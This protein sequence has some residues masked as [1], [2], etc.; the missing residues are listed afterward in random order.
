MR[1]LKGQQPAWTLGPSPSALFG[2]NCPLRP[3]PAGCVA[4]SKRPDLSEMSVPIGLNIYSICGSAQIGKLRKDGGRW[5]LPSCVA[6][7]PSVLP[8]LP[9]G[10]TLNTNSYPRVCSK[11]FTGKGQPCMPPD[12]PLLSVPYRGPAGARVP[13]VRPAVWR[14]P[15]SAGV[16]CS[17][18]QDGKLLQS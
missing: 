1:L 12:Q 18:S 4:P 16:E 15:E 6:C 14:Q 11:A 8:T 5:L 10:Q 13:S 3:P 9:P 17:G 2:K 7:L